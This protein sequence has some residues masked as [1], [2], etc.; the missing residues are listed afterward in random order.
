MTSDQSHDVVFHADVPYRGGSALDDYARERCA[1][2][3][4]IPLD[5]AAF[6]TLVWL[7]GG[8]IKEGARDGDFEKRLGRWLAGQGIALAS[9]G[10]RLSPHARYPEYVDD[11]AAAAQWVLT[12]ISKY[13][14][15]TEHVF[16]GG[17]SAGAYLAALLAMRPS[18]LEAHGVSVSQFAG[19]IPVSAQMFTHW[20]VREERGIER[21]ETTPVIDDAAP[22]YYVR[23]DAPDL[24]VLW[25]DG[26]IPARPEENEYF[27]AIL[28]HAGHSRAQGARIG[29]R[30]HST[31]AEKMVEPND[32]AGCL[33]VDFIRSRAAQG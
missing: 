15:S 21:P 32:P 1:L 17:H 19:F 26:D 6:P 14:G 7:H 10:Y 13:G 2:D 31:I 9:A 33:L 23:P 22:C 3:L 12:N 28:K 30:D 27:L 24:L 20:T 8:G 29:G 4:Y 5:A 25:A 16:V 11:A 18:F